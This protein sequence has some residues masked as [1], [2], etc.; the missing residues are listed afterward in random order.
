M[1]Y[2]KENYMT[3]ISRILLLAVLFIFVMACN[4]VPQPINDAQQA[5]ETV[6]SLATALPVETLQALP[7]ALPVETIESIASEIPD[8]ENFNFFD[9]QG[10]PVDSWNDIPIMSEAIAGQEFPDSNTYSFK[11]DA[12]PQDVQEFYSSHLADLG[13]ETVLSLPIGD[14][15]GI[16]SYSKD[17]NFLTVTI[18]NIDG[19]V[20][21]VLSLV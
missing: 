14:E 18:S 13:W 11:V 17:S 20:V 16:L 6:Q 5:V 21:V 4:F 3:R 19:T 8:F 15:G 2:E 9:P 7:S 1:I 12:T 10:E